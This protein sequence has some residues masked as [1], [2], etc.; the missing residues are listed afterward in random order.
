MNPG[1]GPRRLDAPP[2]PVLLRA[3]V[4]ANAALND[5]ILRVGM[6]ALLVAAI[7]LTASVFLRY[8]L[9]AATDWQDEAA[10]FL[11]VGATFLCSAKVQAQRG[12]IGIEALVGF[13][14]ARANSRGGSRWST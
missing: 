7:V 12:H 3:L 13:L 9:K 5:V 4:R 1:S 14:M 10:V 11:L 6:V 8:F 2:L